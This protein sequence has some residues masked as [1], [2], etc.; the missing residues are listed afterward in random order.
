M[1]LLSSKSPV[2]GFLP[3]SPLPGLHIHHV[4]QFS[5]AT[6]ALSSPSP[7]Q[8]L[9]TGCS[10]EVPRC[11]FRHRSPSPAPVFLKMISFSLMCMPLPLPLKDGGEATQQ[12]RSLSCPC[13][14]ITLPLEMPPSPSSFLNQQR[15]TA[16]E[17]KT[18]LRAEPNPCV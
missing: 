15:L 6:F 2:K 18:P 1:Y 5:N 9:L 11:I 4:N 7:V 3:K 10:T 8:G 17:L 14:H 13:A 16:E 12:A